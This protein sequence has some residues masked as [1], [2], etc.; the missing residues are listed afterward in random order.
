MKESE[1]FIIFGGGGIRGLSYC[2]AYK[3][4][5]EHHIKPTG[6]AGSSIGAVFASLIASKLNFIH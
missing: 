3:A 4:L 1:Y 5:L 6:Y 2:G